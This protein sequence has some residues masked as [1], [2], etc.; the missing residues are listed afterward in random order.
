MKKSEL[1]LEER[2]EISRMLAQ[3]LSFGAIGRQLNRSTSCISREVNRRGLGRGRYRALRAH[4]QAKRY[5]KKQGRKRKLEKNKKLK[6]QVVTWLQK[7]WS[8]QQIVERLKEEYPEDTN[9]R[10]SHETI[11]SYLYIIPKFTLKK[12]LLKCLRQQRWYRRTKRGKLRQG[13]EKRGCI[14]DMV[15]IEARPKE[16]EKRTIPGHWEGDLILGMHRYS[17]LGTLTERLTRITILVPLK[18]KHPETVRLAFA[19]EIKA[20]PKF[21]RLSLTYDQGKEMSLHKLFSQDTKVQVYFAHK[22]SPWERGTN[23]NTNGLIRQFFPKN[24]D[25]D[26]VTRKQIKKVQDLLNDRP[27]RCLGYKKP[28]EVFN[29]LLQ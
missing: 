24:T 1:T 7:K 11:Y 21:M 6:R 9:M 4:H 29:Q 20:L 5:K 19:K 18:D 23:E 15:S 13:Q 10:I 3:G 26:S 25:F 12:E 16:V 14:P 28:I 17:A 27:R 8:P 22:S 2:E